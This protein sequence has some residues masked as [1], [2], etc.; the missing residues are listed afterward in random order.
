VSRVTGGSTPCRCSA[1]EG[2][3]GHDLLRLCRRP[4]G[5][6]ALLRRLRSSGGGNLPGVALSHAR[7][8]VE[9]TERTGGGF[10]RAL[11]YGL[12]AEAH[13]LRQAW[14]EALVACSQA[15][16]IMHGSHINLE[17]EPLVH[18][19]IARAHLG[20]GR[21]A[22]AHPAAETGVRLSRERGNAI[23]EVHART[24]LAQVLLA[25]G[26]ADPT[27][28]RTELEQALEL[29]ERIGFLS[30]QPQIHLRLAELARSTGGEATAA[31]ELDLAY[32][33][34]SAIGADGWLKNLT[35]AR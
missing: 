5:R 25:E 21:L 19:R 24:A 27:L 4:A 17:N 1:R 26:S 3:G 31:Q 28:I 14:D 13:L 2:D 18:T 20:A 34:F 29:T 16:A 15:L 33:Q 8:G 9:L 32:R 23:A 35:A 22:E 10:S 12:L 30:Y 7:R 6:C 11:A